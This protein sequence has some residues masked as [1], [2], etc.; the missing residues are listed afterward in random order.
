M[1]HVHM[2][3]PRTTRTRTLHATLRTHTPYL[4][5]DFIKKTLIKYIYFPRL[6]QVL[7]E[8]RRQGEEDQAFEKRVEG[9]KAAA[10][11]R[12]TRRSACFSHFLFLLPSLGRKKKLTDRLGFFKKLDSGEKETS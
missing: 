11:K 6:A 1:A 10:K 3:T 7:E 9:K 12:A 2:H 8:N 5:S 4:S